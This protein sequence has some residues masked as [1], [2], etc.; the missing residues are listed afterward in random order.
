MAELLARPLGKSSLQLV[1]ARSLGTRSLRVRG[2]LYPCLLLFG[3]AEAYGDI[4]TSLR[5]GGSR[6]SGQ[7]LKKPAV[8]VLGLPIR[9]LQALGVTERNMRA[10]AFDHYGGGQDLQPRNLAH[11]AI[12][13]PR[14]CG[15]LLHFARRRVQGQEHPK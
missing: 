5:A 13:K 9:L 7:G 3:R 2:A 6:P 11:A 10:L 1:L 15:F 12:V 4:G 8:T 14:G